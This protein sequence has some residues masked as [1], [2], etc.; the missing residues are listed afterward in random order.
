MSKR[1]SESDNNQ[2][3]KI[4]YNN[5]DVSDL[6]DIFKSVG[7]DMNMKD[8]EGNTPLMKA[9]IK[10]NINLVS[11]LIKVGADTNAQDEDGEPTLMIAAE[12][13]GEHAAGMMRLFF[14]A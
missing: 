12:H 9:I 4:K 2:S 5:S 8:K 7:I 10:G 6:L 14:D 13:G 1:K 3:K 11:S